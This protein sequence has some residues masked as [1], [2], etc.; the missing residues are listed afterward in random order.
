MQAEIEDALTKLLGSPTPIMGSGRTDTGVHAKQQIAHFDTEKELDALQFMFKLNGFLSS[1]ISINGLYEVHTEAHTRFDAVERSYEYFIHTHKNP[2][3]QQLS[4]YFPKPL[5]V[6][7]MNEAATKLIGTHDFESFS[8]V[9][10]EV[11]NFICSVK[12]ARW[13][14]END[15]LVFHVTANRFLRGMVRA[16]VGT[17]LEVGL[18]K[19]S[20][21]DFVKIIE[22]KDRK[23]AGRAVPAHGLF[24]SKITYPDS[25]YLK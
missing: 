12:E 8:K 2:F 14:M 4:Y 10:T 22:M 19:L 20:T 24:L 9:K 11:N 5:A 18:G 7:Q 23:V 15:S 3:K 16:L 13:Q 25:V 21:E 6:D 1:D 17:L